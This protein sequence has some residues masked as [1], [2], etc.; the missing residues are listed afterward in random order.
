MPRDDV[1]SAGAATAVLGI[2][3]AI[4]ALPRHRAIPS[5]DS[6]KGSL[7]ALNVAH[8]FQLVGMLVGFLGVGRIDGADAPL[9]LSG[10]GLMVA[11]ITVRWTAIHAL[12][13]FF[14]GRVQI[15]AGHTLI[16]TRALFAT[17]SS[18]LCRLSARLLRSRAGVLELVDPGM[19]R[20]ALSGRDRLSDPR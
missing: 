19:Q 15:Q 5:R 9:Q 12:G 18:C 2:W 4:D 1:L 10:L 20:S 14:T 13:G 17:S 6:D 7:L 3:W 11:G 8:G 16:R